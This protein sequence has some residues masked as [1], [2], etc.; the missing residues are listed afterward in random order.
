[1]IS[2]RPLAEFSQYPWHGPKGPVR[3]RSTMNGARE[4]SHRIRAGWLGALARVSAV[5]L[6][7]AQGAAQEPTPRGVPGTSP[8]DARSELEQLF[9]KVEKRL[10]RMSQ[11]LGE[12]SAGDTAALER[13][14]SAGIDEL[15]REAESPP[16]SG[17][18]S[19]I[20]ALIEATQGH[21]RELVQEIDRVL[22]IAREQ[23][24]QQQSPGSSGGSGQPQQPG[25]KQPE[26]GQSP[27]NSRQMQGE[28][29]PQP[30]QDQ[31]QPRDG[32]NPSGN[33]ENPAETPQRPGD[34]PPGADVG[35]PSGAE[36]GGQWGDL[37]VHVRRVFRNGVGEDVPPRYRDWID[38]YHKKLSTRAPR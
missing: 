5:V 19:G 16:P 2:A 36:D 30:G 38:A 4:M 31:P 20:G 18:P 35:A 10:E 17:A 1:M 13:L 8:T 25:G 28:E 23:A 34:Q 37:P 6:L 3:T 15:I 7:A 21:G 12:A 29:A 26:Q 24:Q 33:Q 32:E 14:G 27:E 11:L 22:E 9:A